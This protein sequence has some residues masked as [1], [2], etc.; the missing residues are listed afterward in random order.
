MTDSANV[1][2]TVTYGGDG[3]EP[4]SDQLPDGARICEVYIR[5][6]E[7]VDGIRLSWM[8]ADGSRVDGPYHGGQGG[9][10]A[11]FTLAPG[12]LI[13][14]IRGASGDL[15]DSLAFQTSLGYSYGPYGG[16]GGNPFEENFKTEPGPIVH[17]QVHHPLIGIF[18]RSGD[19]LDAIGFLVDLDFTGG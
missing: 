10:P 15:V 11:S 3:G 17:A 12:E 4:F 9:D 18:G 2:P 16:P 13:E 6:G 5:H 1:R 7:Y 19:V 8:T 14:V